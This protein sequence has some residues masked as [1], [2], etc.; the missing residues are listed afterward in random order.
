MVRRWFS[1]LAVLA[2][3]VLMLAADSSQG[4]QR[5]LGRRF[6]NSSETYVPYVQ[7]MPT[8][9]PGEGMAADMQSEGRRADYYEPGTQGMSSRAR[10]VRLEVRVPA[11]AQVWID[12]TKTQQKGTVRQFISPPIEPGRQYSYKIEAKWMDKG[13]E[14]TRTQTL[15]V[16]PGELQRVD[17]TKAM[18]ES[19]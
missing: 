8:N 12:G 19:Q 1:V 9:A 7:G 5:R 4:R 16:R 10:P 13:N 17:L 3:A 11:D 15:A 14:R 2:V 6:R 18:E